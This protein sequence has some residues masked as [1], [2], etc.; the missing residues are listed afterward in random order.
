MVLQV[1]LGIRM[2]WRTLSPFLDDRIKKK[3]MMTKD[4]H[5]PKIDEMIHPAQLEERYGGEAPNSTEFWPPQHISDEYGHDHD[6]ID[7]NE[8]TIQGEP[9]HHDDRASHEVSVE[10]SHRLPTYKSIKKKTT[11]YMNGIEVEDVKVEIEQSPGVSTQANTTKSKVHISRNS[12][13]LTSEKS[14]QIRKQ[15]KK[16]KNGC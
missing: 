1:T 10:Q 3:I 8:V 9:V 5:H 15:V 13:Q 14:P 7:E 16:A 2:I 6:L 12:S 11:A 4:A